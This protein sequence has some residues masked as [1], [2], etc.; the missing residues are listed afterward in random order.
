MIHEAKRK[1]HLETL[2]ALMVQA[3]WKNHKARFTFNSKIN[4]HKAKF[5]ASQRS[6]KTLRAWRNARRI[7]QIEEQNTR[8]YHNEILDQNEQ[9]LKQLQKIHKKVS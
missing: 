2:A 1:T 5:L 6:M 8:Q 4:P 9:I 3:W 7:A